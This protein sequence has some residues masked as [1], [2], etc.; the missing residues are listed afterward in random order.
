MFKKLAVVFSVVF[1]SACGQSPSEEVV[2]DEAAKFPEDFSVQLYDSGGMDPSS[3][4]IYLSKKNS[5]YAMTDYVEDEYVK[6]YVPFGVTNAQLNEFYDLIEETDFATIKVR[7]EVIYDRG[8]EIVT[9]VLN[10]KQISKSNSGISVVEEEDFERFNKVAGKILEFGSSMTYGKDLAWLLRMGENSEPVGGDLE[11]YL[12]GN[13]VESYFNG[14]TYDLEFKSDV[15]EHEL[16]ARLKLVDRTTEEIGS[17]EK[18]RLV[19]FRDHK[20]IEIQ[21]KD[22]EII[23][24]EMK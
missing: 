8:G 12:D 1:L 19:D 23:F 14:L 11:I 17:I 21:L 15:A 5:F 4:E 20:G 2:N 24:E 18:K 6:M 13:L 9:F 16:V 22:G 7:E 3:M 10:G